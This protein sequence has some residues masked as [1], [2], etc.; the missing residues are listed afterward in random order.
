M[1][2]VFQ[3]M[4]LVWFVD[5]LIVRF[6]KV[7]GPCRSSTLNMYVR[8]S[9]WLLWIATP[10]FTSCSLQSPLALVFSFGSAYYAEGFYGR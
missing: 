10:G 8:L 1:S 7:V 4:V 5:V 3:A 9:S 6:V 2:A